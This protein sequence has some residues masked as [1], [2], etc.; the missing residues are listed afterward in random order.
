[1]MATSVAVATVQAAGSMGEDAVA[2]FH[3]DVEGFAA[4]LG[5]HAL[6]RL[7]Q[8]AC[9]GGVEPPPLDR[10]TTAEWQQSLLE[11]CGRLCE[12]GEVTRDMAAG[13]SMAVEHMDGGEL[14]VLIHDLVLSALGSMRA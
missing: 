7:V 10:A 13:F 4:R 8:D 14:P 3:A 2:Q 5:R 1:M 11:W 9:A 12:R 6:W